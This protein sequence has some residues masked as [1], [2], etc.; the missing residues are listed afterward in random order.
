MSSNMS[1]KY[2]GFRLLIEYPGCNKKVGDFEPFTTG[3]FL[4]YPKIWKPIYTEREIRRQKLNKLNEMS[5]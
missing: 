3:H 2:L 5:I 4:R 1:N